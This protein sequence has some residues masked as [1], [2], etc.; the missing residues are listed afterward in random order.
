MRT[1]QSDATA[2]YRYGIGI[3]V[4]LSRIMPL[5]NAV[6]GS[7]EVL[8]QLPEREGELQYRIKSPGEP[9]QRIAKEG[10]LERA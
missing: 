8:A 3:M 6:P 1:A 4:R 5:R 2:C 10:E 9:Y 7:Y